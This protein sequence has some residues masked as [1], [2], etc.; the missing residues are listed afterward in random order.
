MTN[1]MPAQPGEELTGLTS[2]PALEIARAVRDGKVSP[3]DVVRAHLAQID[4]LEP[5]IRAFQVVLA[6]QALAEARRLAAHP[7]LAALPLAGVPVAV[8]DNV[9]VAGTP[10]RHGSAATPAE[11]A[12]A[13]DE[14]VRRLRAAG[15]VI[16]G[17]TQLPELAIWPFTEPQAYPATRNPWDT[18]RT[19][20]GSTGGGAAALAAGMAALALGSDGGGS[21]RVP[22]ACCGVVGLKPGPGVVPLAGGVQSHWYGLTAFGPL[23]R[24]VGDAAA[25]LDVLTGATATHATPV[26]PDRPLRIAYCAATPVFGARLA[27]SVRA[28]VEDTAAALRDAGHQLVRAR[29]PIPANLGLRFMSRWLAGIAQDAAGLPAA[30]LEERTVKMARR[31]ERVARKVKPAS[32][33]PFAAR[34]ARW[35]S[36]FDALITPTLARPAV[37][38]GTWAG[39]GW[40][41]A[42]L[43]VGNWLCTT[44]WNLAGLPAISVPAPALA[45]GLPVGVQIVA[46]AGGETMV[47]SIAAQLERLRP[48]PQLAPLARL[49]AQDEALVA[50][51]EEDRQAENP[52]SSGPAP[53]AADAGTRSLRSDLS[54]GSLPRRLGRWP[55]PGLVPDP[56]E[57]RRRARHDR[58]GD[59]LRLVVAVPFGEERGELIVAIGRRLEEDEPFLG[60]L[61][62]VIPPVRGRDGPRDLAAGGQPRL[63]GRPG[64]FHRLGP[65][66]RGRLYLQVFGALGVASVASRHAT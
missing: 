16:I 64:E 31:G 29:P 44:P 58:G 11:A 5:R 33:D 27:P 10:T 62:L 4:R 30:A 56:G 45:G 61:E 43:S 50:A 13:D 39:K 14:L 66:V 17:K 2:M 37:P 21:I 57:E 40:F 9:D 24:T 49:V 38:I 54:L 53:A 18:E 36:G 52:V 59:Y 7:G 12:P 22:A 28:A 1:T 41:P 51:G 32:A 46:P 42:A 35:I 48:W 47:L 8:K 15:C 55:W 20:G 65:R 23:A 19:P 25:A 60:A 63:D 34:A 6:Q 3:V 26:L